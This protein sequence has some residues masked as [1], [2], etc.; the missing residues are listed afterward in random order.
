MIDPS[1]IP[2]GLGWCLYAFQGEPV[3]IEIIDAQ[4]QTFQVKADTPDDCWL[5][6]LDILGVDRPQPPGSAYAPDPPV[7]RMK[8]AEAQAAAIAAQ[9]FEPITPPAHAPSPFD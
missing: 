8:A 6:V 4:G 2:P 3:V 7:E 5:Y 9:L 1:L